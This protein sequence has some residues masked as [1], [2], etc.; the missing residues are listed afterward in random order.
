MTTHS[1]LVVSVRRKKAH[2]WLPIS[3]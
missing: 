2:M 3:P 1:I